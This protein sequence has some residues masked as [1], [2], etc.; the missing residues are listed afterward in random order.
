MGKFARNNF[1]PDIKKKGFKKVEV[2]GMKFDFCIGN[3]PYQESDGGGT[4]DSAVPVYNKFVEAS[5][6][7][8]NCLTMITP[9]RWMKG[10]KGL[11]G[12]RQ[13]MMNDT[14]VKGIVDY[15]KAS[16]CFSGNVHI[17][18]GVCYFVIDKNYDGK[19]HF[20]HVCSDGYIDDSERFLASGLSETVIRDS[21][22]ITIIQKTIEEKNFSA[23][24]SAR[25]PYGFCADF[26]NNPE[27]YP[28]VST[29][30][31]KDFSHPIAIYG[32][33]GIKG[34]AKRTKQYIRREDVI[35][36]FNSIDKYKLFFSK[37]YLTTSTVPPEVIQGRPEEICTETFLQIGCFENENE[38]RNVLNYIKTKFARALLFFNRHSLNISKDSFSLIPLQDFTSNSDID[39]SQ[40]IADIDRQLYRKYGLTQEEID[41]IEAHIKEMK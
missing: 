30:N 29:S 4:G 9:S 27:N 11:D 36:N 6:E 28:S 24:V 33:K 7:V 18:G 20:Q 25:N 41:F 16:D 15:E 37:A 17:D 21:R 34:G 35:K 13:T 22:Q 38:M 32:V 10:G 14:S 39:W 26:F 19:C 40:S 23:I 8:A 31:E 5:K 1:F 2:F 12:F 3:P